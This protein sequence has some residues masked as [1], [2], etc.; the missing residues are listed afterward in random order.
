MNIYPMMKAFHQSAVTQNLQE[1][2]S[3]TFL[4]KLISKLTKIVRRELELSYV[5]S[6]LLISRLLSNQEEF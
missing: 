4:P 6:L 5:S 3:C 2:F 1:L